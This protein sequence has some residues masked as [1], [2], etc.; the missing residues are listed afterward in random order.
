[1]KKSEGIITAANSKTMN[2]VEKEALFAEAEINERTP[3]FTSEEELPKTGNKVK[4][5]ALNKIDD[6]KRRKS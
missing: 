1:M 4:S 5:Q 3:D 6:K 2:A